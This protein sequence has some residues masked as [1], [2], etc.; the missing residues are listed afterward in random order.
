MDD[1]CWKTGEWVS[2]FIQWTPKEGAKPSQ[3]TEFKI[4]YDDE[5]IYVAIRAYNKE[6]NKIQ[7]KAGRRD[8]FEGDMVGVCFDSYH[9]YRTGFEFDVTQQDRNL[10]GL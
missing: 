1:E 9:D 5:N 10:M 4:L 3:A 2:D 7:G 6:S 8:E